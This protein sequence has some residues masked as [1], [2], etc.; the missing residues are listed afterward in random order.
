MSVQD[1][2]NLLDQAASEMFNVVNPLNGAHDTLETEIIPRLQEAE[3]EPGTSRTITE[4][5]GAIRRTL[6]NLD[7][8]TQETAGIR[9]MIEEHSAYLT[10][11]MHQDG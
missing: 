4:I 8:L 5:L 9:S 6:D 2:I 11:S 3:G 1:A 7:T 10:A